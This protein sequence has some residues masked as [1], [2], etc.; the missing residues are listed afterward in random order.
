MFG[1]KEAVVQGQWG[2]DRKVRMWREGPSL[3]MSQ[4]K[5]S[6]EKGQNLAIFQPQTHL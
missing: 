1:I 4:P 3:A 2:P 6:P 5:Q